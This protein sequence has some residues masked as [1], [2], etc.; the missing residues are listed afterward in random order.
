M[1]W[2]KD[3]VGWGQQ[4][5]KIIFSDEK[6]FNLDGPDGFR[7]YWHDLRKEEQIFPKRHSG[8]GTVMIWAAFSYKG[9]SEIGFVSPNSTAE[10]YKAM[11][12][13]HLLPV[14]RRLG[15]PTYT[16]MQDNA[17]IHTA[18]LMKRWFQ[19]KK[20]KVLDWPPYSP[21]LNPIENVWGLLA[22]K[23]Y[24]NGKQFDNVRDL[25]TA[26]LRAWSEIDQSYLKN[27]VDSMPKRIGDVIF[28]HGGHTKY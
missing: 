17:P 4:W 16:F 8:T 9:I 5:N 23:V 6:K 18:G 12:Q 24:A 22:R 11:L 28:A 25:K 21:D 26:V 19:E 2:S 3:K 7:Y 14:W 15:G 1:E 27:L 13:T 10:H 20:M